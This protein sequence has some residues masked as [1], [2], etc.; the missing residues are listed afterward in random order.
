MKKGGQAKGKPSRCCLR[1]AVKG[2]TGHRAWPV[3]AARGR[4]EEHKA[5]QWTK[6]RAASL[7]FGRALQLEETFSNTS[8]LN[9]SLFA[10]L[11]FS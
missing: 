8:Y 7:L 9:L 5:D 1:L 6:P 2:Y 3:E 4:K 10:F 11:S